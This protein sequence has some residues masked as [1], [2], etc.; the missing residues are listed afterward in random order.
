MFTSMSLRRWMCSKR[1]RMVL[2]VSDIADVGFQFRSQVDEFKFSN[3]EA[4]V[5]KHKKKRVGGL[6]ET[7]VRL[8]QQQQ[9]QLLVMAR[10]TKRRRAS[11]SSSSSSSLAE[12]INEKVKHNGWW[13]CNPMLLDVSC[14][15]DANCPAF[16]RVIR[17]ETKSCRIL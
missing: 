5:S 12:S 17:L 8:Q 11:S 4:N 3:F 15:A 1:Q 16:R 2:E 7:A 14:Q 10:F 6:E 9:Q 13:N